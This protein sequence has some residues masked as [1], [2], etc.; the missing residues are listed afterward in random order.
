[1][2]Y[3]KIDTRIIDSFLLFLI[4]VF[5]FYTFTFIKYNFLLLTVAGLFS[6]FSFFILREL[7][8]KNQISLTNI[9]FVFFYIIGFVLSFSNINL[10]QGDYVGV[11][12]NKIGDFKFTNINIIFIIFLSNIFLFASYLGITIGKKFTHLYGKQRISEKYLKTYNF[13]LILFFFTFMTI[14]LIFFM[15]SIGIGKH[16]LKDEVDLFGPLNGLLRYLKGGIF[17]ATCF[18]LYDIVRLHSKLISNY[19][20]LY[21]LVFFIIFFLTNSLIGFSRSGIIFWTIPLL[22]PYFIN[23]KIKNFILLS[24]IFF[25]IIIVFMDVTTEYRSI[26]DENLQLQS[27]LNYFEKFNKLISL[28]SFNFIDIKN[29]INFLTI[30]IEGTKE[31]MLVFQS[32]SFKDDFLTYYFSDYDKLEYFSNKIWKFQL[33]DA[34]AWGRTLGIFGMSYLAKSII[35]LFFISFISF[36]ILKLLEEYFLIQRYYSLSIYFTIT[37]FVIIWNNQTFEDV[38]RRL[39]IVFLFIFVIKVINLFIYDQKKIITRK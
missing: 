27:N 10:N 38:S 24:I 22:L 9:L 13:N 21:F 36:F 34:Y 31:L 20:K 18:Y 4:F 6:F 32:N 28:I 15:E 1:M 19:V 12:W 23:L 14:L 26:F 39:L 11:G 2:L 33:N 29:F 17:F 3:Q 30:R 35:L 7:L 37:L 16:G 8:S 25:F 5:I